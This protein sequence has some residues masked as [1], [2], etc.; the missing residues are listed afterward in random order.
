M[1]GGLWRSSLYTGR[2]SHQLCA[3]EKNDFPAS[4]VLP[5]P[6]IK[7]DFSH[8]QGGW[9][10]RAGELMEKKGPGAGPSL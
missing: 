1:V 8:G 3:F 10:E 2:A 9:G 6:S 7:F 5:D 4:L